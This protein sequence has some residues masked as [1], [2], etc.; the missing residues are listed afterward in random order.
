MW[1]CFC[2]ITHIIACIHIYDY[3][4]AVFLCHKPRN[5]VFGVSTWDSWTD[6]QTKK[7]TGQIGPRWSRKAGP[8]GPV[9]LP[10][11]RWWL[12]KR[13]FRNHQDDGWN[14][15][16]LCI[17]KLV[18]NYQKKPRQEYIKHFCKRVNK[19]IIESSTWSACWMFR[20]FYL[21]LAFVLS[22]K[23]I[24]FVKQSTFA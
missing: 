17:M 19:N 1:L 4:T 12:W 8:M 11:K 22:P 2:Y 7:P 20:S 13:G 21:L 24:H 10:K 3:L 16:F 5:F 14:D 9:G 6:H 18:W 23:I 15:V